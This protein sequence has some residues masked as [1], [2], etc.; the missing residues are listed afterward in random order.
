MPTKTLPDLQKTCF[1][2]HSSRLTSGHWQREVQSQP[3]LSHTLSKQEGKAFISILFIV[4]LK[5]GRLM[6]LE[7]RD[8]ISQKLCNRKRG[9]KLATFHFLLFLSVKELNEHLSRVSVY[10]P[11]CINCRWM[12]SCCRPW[13][14]HPISGPNTLVSRIIVLKQIFFDKFS[15]TWASCGRGKSQHRLS[16]ASRSLWETYPQKEKGEYSWFKNNVHLVS[17]LCFL[18]LCM[19]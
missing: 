18:T 2:F 9:S 14:A 3:L 1:C 19:P 13:G 5:P 6:D 16:A 4:L 17:K 7:W 10:H 12:Y 15:H 8:K 11:P